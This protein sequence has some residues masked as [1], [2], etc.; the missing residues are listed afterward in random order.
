MDY[1]SFIIKDYKNLPSRRLR[2]A[3][4]RAE[5]G[6]GRVRPRLGGLTALGVALL[7]IAGTITWLSPGFGLANIWSGEDPSPARESTRRITRALP[8]PPLDGG[9]APEEPAAGS[10]VHAGTPAPP[11]P[12][13]VSHL[14]AQSPTASPTHPAKR[15]TEQPVG[16]AS[17][18]DEP[19]PD[20][21]VSPAA[22]GAPEPEP[23]PGTRHEVVIRRGDSLSGIFR[24]LEL[25]QADLQRVMA[26]GDD[27]KQLSRIHPGQRLELLADSDG[28]LHRLTYH[29]DETR[30]L[31]VTRIDEAY[32]TALVEA[33]LEQRLVSAS[34]TIETSLFEAGQKAGLSNNLIMKLVEIFA[35]DVDFALDIRSGDRFTV[36]YEHLYK[37]GEKLGDGNILAAEF[38]NRGRS[39]RAVRYTHAGGRT[40]YYTPEGL[41][42][43]KAFLRTP[44][45]FSRV[46][47]RFNL[48][49][50]HPVLHRV[51]A[52]RGVDYA[53]PPGTAVRATGDGK[54]VLA[55]R[56]GGYGKTVVL[57]HGGTYTTV[58][59]HLSRFARRVRSGRYVAQGQTIGYVGSTGL[60]TGPHLHYEFRVRGVHR[61][62]LTVRLPE[63]DPI[64]DEYREDFVQDT[65]SLLTHLDILSRT[66]VA[67]SD[68]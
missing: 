8:L 49:R 59:A 28:N 34:G 19:S 1:N 29:L 18:T 24:R 17:D 46:S 39:L 41:S 58:Y 44:V 23:V 33:E 51:R 25:R 12:P 35:W 43:R 36:V 68:D 27:A 40:D 52:H 5:A 57:R 67:T 64:P 3:A 61:D 2:S 53:A 15:L 37:D 22:A 32:R 11:S 63:A 65:R 16:P 31:E 10:V 48:R 47:S 13:W 38:V 21:D 4:A 62:P 20:P 54:V 7:A 9:T 56:K 26:S 55:G 14:P 30:S 66:Q 45:K 6:R 60:A 42:M 50:M